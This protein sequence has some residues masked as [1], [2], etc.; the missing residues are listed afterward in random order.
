MS[1]FP[2]IIKRNYNYFSSQL[3]PSAPILE[4]AQESDV[5]RVIKFLYRLKKEI[6]DFYKKHKF[7][8]GFDYEANYEDLYYMAF[9]VYDNKAG[10]YANPAVQPLVEKIIL[11]IRP[12]LEQKNKS[13]ELTIYDLAKRS[14]DYI[15]YV[16]FNLLNQ[17]TKDLAYLKCIQ[18][19][20][21]DKNFSK[22]DIFTLNH[23]TVLE[24]YLEQILARNNINPNYALII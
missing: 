3:H 6:Q 10:E 9:Q 1:N 15:E 17:G 11:D 13:Q 4:K 7:K 14:I 18:Q 12:L 19:A 5:K 16:V 23:D 20:C 24:K 21:E 2:K 8:P 22:I